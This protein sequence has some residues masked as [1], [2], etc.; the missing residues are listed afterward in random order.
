MK[1]TQLIALSAVAA[2]ALFAVEG[3]SVSES[4]GFES[5]HLYRGLAVANE[6][7]T[8][9]VDAS[10]KLYNGSLYASV[11]AAMPA[12]NSW[13]NEVDTTIGYKLPVYGK[14]T[15]DVGAT[16]YWFT[17]DSAT[18]SR[19][20]EVFAGVTYAGLYV[21][22]AVYAYYDFDLQAW[23]VDVSGSYSVDL[24]KYGVAKTSLDLGAH[25]GFFNGANMTEFTN[26]ADNG[27]NGYAFYGASADVVYH[28]SD[29]ASASVGA[30]F[31]GNN[32]NN[33]TYRETGALIWGVKLSAGF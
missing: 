10:Y 21:N 28:F 17:E 25:M 30:S 12:N 14:Y 13:S 15:A 7:V 3:L 1:I 26:K 11:A 5:E 27:Q 8:A 9:S 4:I 22:P 23:T 6:T 29:S 33:Q 18:M 32:D 24:A 19:S 16:Y 20:R 2:G 31:A